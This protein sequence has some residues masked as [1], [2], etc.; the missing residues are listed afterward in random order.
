MLLKAVSVYMRRQLPIP[1]PARQG[2]IVS[3]VTETLTKEP[4]LAK[5]LQESMPVSYKEKSPLVFLA[6][7]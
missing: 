7:L 6:F 1:G 4:K 5:V 3:T 2:I